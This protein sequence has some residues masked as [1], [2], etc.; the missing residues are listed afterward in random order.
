MQR[1]RPRGRAAR[2]HLATANPT[3]LAPIMPRNA[4]LLADQGRMLRCLLVRQTPQKCHRLRMAEL[5]VL[6]LD[7]YAAF[8]CSRPGGTAP[9]VRGSSEIGSGPIH[10]APQTPRLQPSERRNRTMRKSAK[11]TSPKKHETHSWQLLT[12]NFAPQTGLNM[13]NCRHWLL[14]I[15]E[16]LRPGFSFRSENK[17][18]GRCRRRRGENRGQC[19]GKRSSRRHRETCGPS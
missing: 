9:A 13:Q 18:G 4:V 3:A 1:V 19:K 15:K 14:T 12:P 5:R 2:R 16:D 10:A 8:F 6:C 11:Q 7:R 17:S